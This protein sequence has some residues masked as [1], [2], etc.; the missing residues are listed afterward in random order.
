MQR[1]YPT[2]G[3]RFLS[4]AAL[5]IGLI[6]AVVGSQVAAA[7]V[8]TDPVGFITL[9]VQGSNGVANARANSFQGLGMTQI[10]T[11]RGAIASFVT[12][13]ITDA[14]AS[15]VANSY[16][17]GLFF[18]EFLGGANAGLIDDVAGANGQ[19]LYTVHD[20]SA[21]IGA[22]T[23]YKIY[24]H[25]TIGTVFGPT[26]QAGLKQGTATTADFIDIFNPLTQTFTTYFYS[27]GGASGVGWRSSGSTDRQF[28]KLYV[29]QGFLVSR[30][31]G[32]NITVLL[33]G[34]VK[35]GQTIE[36]I[37]QL[38]NFAGNVYATAAM[39]LTNSNLL[40]NDSTKSLTG[41]TATTGDLVQIF[42]PAAGTFT[43][44][45]WSTGGASGVGWRSSGATDRG[46]TPI[47]LGQSVLIVRKAPRA[48]INWYV[49]AP[50]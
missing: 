32:T 29:D 16:T 9:T 45:F 48:A 43:S 33:P 24:P 28:T 35:L 37:G 44:Y 1:A 30:N 39:T 10:P 34:A 4:T 17:N 23:S 47:P 15:Y 12:N 14:N 49:P 20:N 27:S 42:N 26:D 31:N 50:Y 46:T 11:N 41:G 18:I 6:T 2:R 40:N 22:S 38:N 3:I 19:Q 25:W 13:S 5:S 7:D 21:Q 8:F 36:P